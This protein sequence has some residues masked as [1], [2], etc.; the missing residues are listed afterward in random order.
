M[1][2]NGKKKFINNSKEYTLT[3]DD[4]YHKILIE[5]NDYKIIITNRQYQL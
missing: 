4:K 3:K 2:N 1:K 5:H